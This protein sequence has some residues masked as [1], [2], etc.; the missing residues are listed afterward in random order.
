VS[1]Q[2][3]EELEVDVV[4]CLSRPGGH[5][6]DVSVAT[7]VIKWSCQSLQRISPVHA[8]ILILEEKTGKV[9]KYN[10]TDTWQNEVV[11]ITKS[12]INFSFLS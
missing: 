6:N 8:H 11:S 3:C 12:R 1:G 2:V 7:S 9:G 10:S 5:L 4:V